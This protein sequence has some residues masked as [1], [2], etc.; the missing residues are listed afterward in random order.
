[1]GK[2]KKTLFQNTKKKTTIFS[3]L[4][5]ALFVLR[6]EPRGLYGGAALL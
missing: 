4:E 3:K 1:M 2:E 6:S 5:A